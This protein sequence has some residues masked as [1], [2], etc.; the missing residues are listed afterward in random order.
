[1]FKI[2]MTELPKNRKKIFDL[3]FNFQGCYD[4]LKDVAIGRG[5]RSRACLSAIFLEN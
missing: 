1:M 3:S 4:D 5:G 2:Q